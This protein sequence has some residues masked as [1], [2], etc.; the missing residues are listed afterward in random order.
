MQHQTPNFLTCPSVPEISPPASEGDRLRAASLQSLS[1]QHLDGAKVMSLR[2]R[3]TSP[4]LTSDA[5][6]IHSQTGD[7]VHAVASENL[8]TQ[9]RWLRITI[10]A[11]ILLLFVLAAPFV[12]TMSRVG[13]LLYSATAAYAQAKTHLRSFD[14][15]AARRELA[16]ARGSLEEAHTTLR[17]TGAWRVIPGIG[18]Q[19]RAMEDGIAASAAILAAGDELLAAGQTILTAFRSS[20]SAAS[21]IVL[22]Q[23][24]IG[25]LTGAERREL[26][27]NVSL[28][29]PRLRLAR[30]KI[31]IASELWNRVPQSDLAAPLRRALRPVAVALPS[32]QRALRSGIPL[33]EAAGPLMG[34]PEKLRYL[35]LLQNSDELRPSGGFLGVVGS[36]LMD[37]GEVQDVSFADVYSIDKRVV[38]SWREVP[39]APLAQHLGVSAWYLRD[40]NW[41]PDFPTSAERALDFYARETSSTTPG[42]AVALEPAFFASLLHLVGPIVID[43]KAYTDTNFFDQLQYDVE[44]GFAREGIAFHQR[45]DIVARL[46]AALLDRLRTL[47]V[48]RW[49]TF[50]ELVSDALERKHILLYAR[51][52]DTLALL[53]R[54]GWTGRAQPT[55]G[56]ILWIVDANMAALKTDGVM[57]KD[58]TY[59]LDAHDL[60][61][62]VARVK[63]T[64]TNTNPTITWR[65]TRYRS[66][67]RVYVPEGS[68]LLSSRGAMKDDVY[69]TGGV[70]V[71]GTVDVMRD[72][73]KTVFGAFWSIEPGQTGA[74]EFTYRLPSMVSEQIAAGRYHLDWPKQPGADT[75]R[76]TLDLR[77]GKKL[78]SATPEEDPHRW[79][80]A[81]YE[82]KTDSLEDRKFEMRFMRTE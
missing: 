51:K 71:P 15:D 78:L 3:E 75:T 50:A 54:H 70:K 14:V 32:L 12:V 21:D 4:V 6:P 28:A 11:S 30:D 82:F 61:N 43:G 8:L 79:G 67:T 63:L 36:A 58:V 42:A 56:D 57:R 77:F 80:D 13:F 1:P 31:D 49:A 47:S 74:L 39:P 19:L 76:L 68:I 26:L 37:A 40:A 45:K 41:S 25:E 5:Q 23:K 38:G 35:I 17:R 73:G 34:Y 33:L 81:R 64:Y 65:Y 52:L 24:Q 55:V 16:S 9:R 18:T 60:S 22:P 72:L 59:E 66:Y 46:G 2:D 10:I 44:Q 48:D 53:D 27:R 62:M 20:I 7:R 29:L 69:R